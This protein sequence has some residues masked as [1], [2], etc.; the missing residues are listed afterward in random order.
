[1]V[2]GDAATVCGE[3]PELDGHGVRGVVG[4][5]ACSPARRAVPARLHGGS[6]SLT[7]VCVREHLVLF[8]ASSAARLV[9]TIKAADALGIA[10]DFTETLPARILTA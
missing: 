9:K 3:A 10:G 7:F 2:P 5:S 6:H 8:A 1:M 4:D